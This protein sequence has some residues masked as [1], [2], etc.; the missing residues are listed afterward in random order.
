M[1]GSVAHQQGSGGREY[2]STQ[3][4]DNDARSG[5]GQKVRKAYQPPKVISIERLEAAA[6][7]CGPPPNPNGPGKSVPLQCS[8]LGS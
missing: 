6:S 5:A 3:K 8:T 1:R 2:E 7:T 4:H